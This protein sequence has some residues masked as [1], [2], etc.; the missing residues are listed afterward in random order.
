M[1]APT[2]ITGLRT[3]SRSEMIP[4]PTSATQF[5]AQYKV[6]R[7]LADASDR[8]CTSTLYRVRKPDAVTKMT[9]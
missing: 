6:P 1:I 5:A 3:S 7:S 4:K 8:C 9:R 2:I